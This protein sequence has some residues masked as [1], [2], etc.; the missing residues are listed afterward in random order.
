VAKLNEQVDAYLRAANFA[1]APFSGEAF[2]PNRDFIEKPVAAS[3]MDALLAELDSKGKNFPADSPRGLL[4]KNTRPALELAAKANPRWSEPHFR[5]A[6][7]ETNNVAKIAELKIATKLEPRNVEYWQVLAEA[8]LGAEQFDD[9]E[10]SWAAAEHAART[11]AERARVRQART[12]FVERRLDLEAAEKRRI[13]D[14]QARELQRIKDAAAAEVHAAE[15]AA[16]KR[17]GGFKSDK[18]VEAWWDNPQ[19]DKVSGKLARVDCLKGPLRLTIQIDGGGTIRLLIRDPNKLV[20]QG[21]KEALFGC[22]V[23]RPVRNIRV[24]YNVKADAKL[25]TVGEI[26]MVE[27]P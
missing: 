26:A 13:A 1:A 22:G 15:E 18:P 17:L 25:D 14:E 8:Q 24:V 11:E 3:V 4:A 7:L 9:A 6:A 2:N 16:N 27:F 21:S 10:K 20:V 19:G 23:Q 12:D 5:L